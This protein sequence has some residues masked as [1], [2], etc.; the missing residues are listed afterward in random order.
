MALN[1]IEVY[2]GEDEVSDQVSSLKK[3][4]STPQLP[5]P[6]NDGLGLVNAS[7]KWNEVEEV[8][9]KDKGKDKKNDDPPHHDHDSG[10]PNEVTTD[11]DTD[12][13]SAI[14]E[15]T[16]HRFELRDV[17]VMFPEGELSVV[18]GPTASGKTALLVCFLSPF[19]YNDSE[20]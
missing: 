4:M 17:T 13:G 19:F 6:D 7:F 2:L 9:D 14:G 8:K 5:D 18:T 16:E 10:S 20:T 15:M 11:A 3:D 1:R 12:V